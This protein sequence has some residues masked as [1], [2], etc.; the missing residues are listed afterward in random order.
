MN[1]IWSFLSASLSI[2][3]EY[4]GNISIFPTILAIQLFTV[5]SSGVCNCRQQYEAIL[6]K[7][8][9]ILFS[10]IVNIIPKL[11]HSMC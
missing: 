5:Q 6:V 7:V 11:L 2:L 9:Q 1:Y 8:E 10:D 3:L 4:D